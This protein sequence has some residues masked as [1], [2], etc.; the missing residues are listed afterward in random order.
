MPPA[1]QPMRVRGLCTPGEGT[2]G[3]ARV[4]EGEGAGPSGREAEVGSPD[5]TVGVGAGDSLG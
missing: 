1:R 2:C 5:P 3:A 4:W